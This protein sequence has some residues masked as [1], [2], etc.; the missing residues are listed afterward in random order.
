[1]SSVRGRRFLPVFGAVSAIA[2][3]GCGSTG[4]DLKQT[5]LVSSISITVPPAGGFLV[6][7]GYHVSATAIARNASGDV[8][9]VPF[10]WRSSNE[11]VFTVD[12]NGRI[13]AVD[14]GIAVIYATT[15]DVVSNQVPVRVTWFGAAK[16][17]TIQF[18]APAAITPGATPDSIRAIV[19]DLTGAPVPNVRVSFAVTGGGGTI[20]PAI[21]TTTSKGIASAEWKLGSTAGTNTATATVLGEEDKASTFI[22]PNSVTFSLSTFAAITAVD[23][24][25]QTGQI[26]S[27]LPVNPSV[28]L[29]DSLGKPRPGVSVTFSTTGG[30]RVA[31]TTVAT[32]A[33]GIASP[34]AWTLGDASGDQTLVAKAAFATTILHATATGTA[35]HYMPASVTAGSFS[36]CAIETDGLTS[37]WGEQP[38]VGDGSA[39]NRP[40]P[41]R[42]ASAL[43]FLSV[44][45]SSVNPGRFCGVSSGQ[46]VLCWGQNA[47]SDAAGNPVTAAVPTEVASPQAFTQVAPGLIHT[48]ALATDQSAWCW[49]DNSR[50][51][52]GDQT[53]VSR[54]APALVFGGFTFT[55]IT[56]GFG[57][58]CG[59]ASDGSIFCW[60]LNAN[61]QLGNGT[62]TDANSP[63]R[64]SGSQTFKQISAGQ[65]FT[66]GL[67][68]AGRVYCWGNLDSASPSVTTLR[69]Y[70]AAP[71]FTTISAGAFHTCALTVDGTPYC[72]GDNTVGQLGDSTFVERPSPTA[73]STTI[74]FKS[75]SAGVGHSCG[76]ALDGSIACW[77]VN[78]AGELGDSISVAPFRPTPRFIVL[79][80]TP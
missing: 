51:Q 35:V 76:A 11:K 27:R 28:K 43:T 55:A 42:T 24:D 19:K 26:L 63:V 69:T 21:A 7:R 45:G 18:N 40:K 62:T 57:H 6:E 77:G 67:T 32:G 70:P 15:V 17:D 73:V 66:C 1:M 44:V 33:N 78:K 41:T 29:V 64:V 2:V 8:V 56:A 4:P 30:G 16:I 22:S 9:S 48:C 52:L 60:G 25:A 79:S 34:G 54:G 14:T 46:T 49:G 20:S 10:A 53:M 59:L 65:S 61:G 37:C 74:K 47:L 75:I 68:T 80:V 12:I 31:L 36:T 3:L 13:A 72:W 23:G 39:L 50:S 5:P 58:T 71:D 38:K